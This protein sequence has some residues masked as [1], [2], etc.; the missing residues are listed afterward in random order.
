MFLRLRVAVREDRG[1]TV[2]RDVRSDAAHRMP[3]LS[4][5]PPGSRPHPVCTLPHPDSR[6]LGRLPCAGLRESPRGSGPPPAPHGRR[7]GGATRGAREIA[8]SPDGLCGRT[9]V[10]LRRRLP[11]RLVETRRIAGCTWHRDPGGFLPIQH[12]RMP[13]S[14]RRCDP[15]AVWLQGH[16]TRDVP[17]VAHACRSTRASILPCPTPSGCGNVNPVA[18]ASG[19]EHGTV[20]SWPTGPATAPWA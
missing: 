11:R 12:G 13:A 9:S 4:K 5:L 15:S 7:D 8:R 14:L 6:P 1:R 2:R 16:A 3:Q 18:R 19:R 10:Q 17:R 20:A